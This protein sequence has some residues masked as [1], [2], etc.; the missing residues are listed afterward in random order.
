M[1]FDE[2]E[3]AFGKTDKEV[4]DRCNKAFDSIFAS[5]WRQSTRVIFQKA[6]A[7]VTVSVSASSPLN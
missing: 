4:L 5:Y 6:G 1:T 7:R 2:Y 3:A